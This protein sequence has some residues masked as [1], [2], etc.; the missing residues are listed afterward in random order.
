[1]KV[2]HFPAESFFVKIMLIGLLCSVSYFESH[3]AAK[4]HIETL[5]S[6]IVPRPST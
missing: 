1:M 5:N 6:R 3:C 2:S 4:Y